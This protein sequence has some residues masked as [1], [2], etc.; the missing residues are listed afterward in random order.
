MARNVYVLGAGASACFGVPTMA[1]FIDRA[2]D[3]R[4][5]SSEINTEDFDAFFSA[6]QNG[7]GQLHAKTEVDLQNIESV[8]GL[9]EMAGLVRRLPGSEA[10]DIDR[11]SHSVRAV[12]L[13]TVVN[14]GRF[15]VSND[16]WR[17][18]EPY[19]DLAKAVA[20]RITKG[21][22]DVAFITFNYDLGLDYALHWADVDVDYGLDLPRSAAVPLLKLHG[23][24]NWVTCRQCRHVRPISISEIFRPYQ[25]RISVGSDDSLR[26]LNPAWAYQHVQP[27]CDGDYRP[28]ETTLV[29]PSWNKAQYWEQL[30]GVWARAAAEL[31]EAVHIRVIG[32]SLPPTDSFFR[33]LLALGLVGPSRVRSFTVIDR[34]GAATQ[35]FRQLLGPDLRDRFQPVQTTFEQWVKAQREREDGFFD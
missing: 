30:A 23:S 10:V 4:T 35:R 24:V 15:Q 18:P 27:H 28:Y 14:A 5:T 21:R 17:P 11:L 34:D 12:V 1:E 8:F 22:R 25:G 2:D 6:L 3:L 32:Y 13:E 26:P 16:I 19:S 29:P 7:L 9:I 31:A 33:D 20:K